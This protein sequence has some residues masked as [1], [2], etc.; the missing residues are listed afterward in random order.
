MKEIVRDLKM[1]G[2]TSKQRLTVWYFALSLCSLCVSDETPLWIVVFLVLN[3]ANAARLVR[4][5]PMP[6]FE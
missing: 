4:K 2:L 6:K 1:K 5:V 3:F